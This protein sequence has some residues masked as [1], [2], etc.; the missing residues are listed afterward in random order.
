MPASA[1]SQND[2]VLPM[3]ASTSWLIVACFTALVTLGWH[4]LAPELQALGFPFIWGYWFYGLITAAEL[5]CASIL[6]K[7]ERRPLTWNQVKT[8]CRLTPLARDGLL[9]TGGVLVIMLISY[10]ILTNWVGI[11]IATRTAPAYL[12]DIVVPGK[13]AGIPRSV[14]GVNLPGNYWLLFPLTLQM[15]I[16]PIGEELLWRGVIYPRMEKKLGKY[17]WIHQGFQGAFFHLFFWWEA[18]MLLPGALLLAF[19]AYRTRSTSYTLLIHFVFDLIPRVA[20]FLVIFQ[21]I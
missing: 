5:V 20:F 15:L 17:A 7:K 11:P 18:L 8:R 10:G 1:N 19:L 13:N 2:G 14:M 4:V 3:N 6:L 16:T 12:P 9:L 21:V